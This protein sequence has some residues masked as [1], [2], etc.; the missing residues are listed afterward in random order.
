MEIEEA[1]QK[2][3]DVKDVLQ[4]ANV[5]GRPRRYG[6]HVTRQFRKSGG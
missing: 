5:E 4:I 3:I 6:Q 2:R 1:A